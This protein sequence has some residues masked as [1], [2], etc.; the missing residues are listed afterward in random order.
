MPDRAHLLRL[1]RAAHAQHDG[2]GRLDLVAR[3][4]RAFRQHQ[5]HARRLHPV[6]RL[7]GA[8]EL[9]LERAQVIDVLNERSRPEGVGFV[10]DLVSDAAALGQAAFGELHA[11]PGQPVARHHHDGA[12]VL[13]FVRDGLALEIL[14]DRG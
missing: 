5:V 12:V 13:E 8:R 10:E 6:D 3:E 7:D 2:G 11:H 9:P 4:Q 14:H 1:Q